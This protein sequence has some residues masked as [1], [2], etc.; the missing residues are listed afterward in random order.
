MSSK[1]RALVNHEEIR[2][3]ARERGAEPSTVRRTEEDDNASIIRL[4][5]P[6]LSV[7]GL[8]EEISW[9]EWFRDFDENDLALIVE[10]EIANGHSRNFYKLVARESLEGDSIEISR[11]GARKKSS[12]RTLTTER[13]T[14]INGPALTKAA[15]SSKRTSESQSR[16]QNS[17]RSVSG[18]KPRRKAA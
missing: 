7:Q 10:D 2:R 13:A 8:L 12:S 6:G 15:G 11:P 18:H 3:W 16:E 17:K 14:K 9:D 4:D 1:W 5:F